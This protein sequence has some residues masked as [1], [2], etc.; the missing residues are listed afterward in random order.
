MDRQTCRGTAT[1][2]QLCQVFGLTRQA[3]SKARR[4]PRP[5]GPR[6]PPSA[7]P[8]AS[9]EE[10]VAGIRTVVGEQ[11]GWGTRKVWAVLRRRKLVVSR[12]RVWAVMRSL[13]LVLEPSGEP[14]ELPGGHVHVEGSN[15]RWASDLTTVWTRKDGV[16]AITPVVDCGDRYVLACG[17]DIPQDAPTVLL[18]IETALHD[19]FE[20]AKGVPWGFELLTDHGTQY[21]GVDCKDLCAT[22]AVDHLFSRVGRPTGNA[23]AERLIKT[24]KVELIWTRDWDSLEDLRRAV[25]AWMNT[26]NHERPHQALGW[27]T[28]AEKR[29]KNLGCD[30]VAA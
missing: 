6:P 24:L 4:A 27:L 17:V 8:Y 9:H 11:P 13:G 12:R 5:R 14:R 15:R 28:P 10:L 26:C 29:A 25:A 1:V 16:V 30:K 22:W 23:L 3:L 20:T 19:E 18:P 2:K 7:P 21:T